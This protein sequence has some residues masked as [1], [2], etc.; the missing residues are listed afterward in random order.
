[1]KFDKSIL[2]LSR[3]FLGIAGIFERANPDLKVTLYQAEL[4]ISVREYLAYALV[5]SAGTFL[6]PLLGLIPVSGAIFGWAAQTFALLFLL[7]IFLGWFQFNYF[8]LLPKL[9]VARR[10]KEVDKDLLFA[11]RHLL[12][13]IRSGITL[14]ESMRGISQGGYGLVS[15]EFGRIVS[16]ISAG[17]GEIEV[18]EEAAY[19]NTSVYF[20]RALWQISSSMRAGADIGNTLTSIVNNLSVEQ[21]ISIRK[22]GS[23]LSP[24]ALGY[25]MITVIIPTLGIS[26]M[27]VLSQMMASMNIGKQVFFIVY[28]LVLVCQYFLIG[29]I[30]TRRPA[31]DV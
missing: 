3:K 21:R 20:R 12:I 31:I 23:E 25:M 8:I 16:E 14:F 28:G 29:V 15:T 1:M 13:K 24:L 27:I 5:L 18:L 26:I 22:Y 6:F 9:L 2:K 19:R 11:L 4:G 10:A 17:K 30:R 7:C